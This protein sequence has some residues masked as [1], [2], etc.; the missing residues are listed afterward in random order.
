VVFYNTDI[1]M[2]MSVKYPQI[3]LKLLAH[4]FLIP[5]QSS[6]NQAFEKKPLAVGGLIDTKFVF[7]RQ[8]GG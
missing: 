4:L 7:G 1:L 3:A 8:V 5:F 2:K 6:Q